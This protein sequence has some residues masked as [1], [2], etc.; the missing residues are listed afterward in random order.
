MEENEIILCEQTKSAQTEQ[1][2]STF[3]A[4]ELEKKNIELQVSYL[5]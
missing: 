5:T 2:I 3:K 4:A 1:R